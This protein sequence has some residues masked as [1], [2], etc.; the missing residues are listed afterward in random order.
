MRRLVSACVAVLAIGTLPA[1]AA[2][3]PLRYPAKGPPL[4][5]PIGPTWTGCFLGF[6]VGGGWAHKQYND[7]ILGLDLESNH[8]TGVVGGGQIGCDYQVGVVVVG[9]QGMFN[10]AHL[11]GRHFVNPIFNFIETK[12][13]WYAT[14]TARVGFAVNPYL[15]AY[16]RGGVAWVTYE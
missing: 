6:N 5:A 13:P 4:I 8:V 12:I 2:D 14:A 9:V 16:V 1:S 7:P 10:G 11:E 3:V 15:L